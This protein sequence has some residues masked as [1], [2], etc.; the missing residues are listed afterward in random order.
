MR[1]ALQPGDQVSGTTTDGGGSI[2]ILLAAV[3]AMLGE[4]RYGCDHI[5]QQLA[6]RRLGHDGG[7]HIHAHAEAVWFGI[8]DKSSHVA[9]A[10]PWQSGL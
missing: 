5:A 7:N 8:L 6:V 1:G 10:T 4:R 9:N 3:P 2:T